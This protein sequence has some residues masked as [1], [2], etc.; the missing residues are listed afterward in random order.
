MSKHHWLLGLCLIAL[1]VL[2]AKFNAPARGDEET[3]EPAI[4]PAAQDVANVAMAY[5][6]AEYG[7]K[8]RAPE[9]LVSAARILRHIKGTPSNAKPEIEAPKGEQAAEDKPAE[10]ASLMEESKKLLDEAKKMA[11]DDAIITELIERIGKE[12][13]RGSLGG[14]RT[15]SG[16]LRKGSAHKWGV[17][18]AG[19]QTAS[20]SVTGNGVAIFSLEAINDAGRI[21]ATSTGR[22]PSISWVPA[23]TRHFTVRVRNVGGGV[24]GYTLYH[25]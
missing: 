16:T 8:H 10:A 22:F 24:S 23:S 3:K 18:F 4:S 7:R 2:A 20:V 19:R 9:M 25:N 15:F 14:P 11:P 5:R 12:K 17:N 13:T 1:S 21:V 6:L